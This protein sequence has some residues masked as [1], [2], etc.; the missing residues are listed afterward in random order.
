MNQFFLFRV[1]AK[2]PSG[3]EEA[4]KIAIVGAGLA[5]VTL[6]IG[7]L[8]QTSIHPSSIHLYE[9]AE[10]FSEIGAGVASG[11]NAVRAL[12]LISPRIAEAYAKCVTHNRDHS[13]SST[14]LGLRWGMSSKNGLKKTEELIASLKYEPPAWAD[15][16]ELVPGKPILARSCVH[17][18]AFLEELVKFIP[19]GMCSFN[20]TLETISDELQSESVTLTF[21]DGTTAD[22]DIVIGCDGVKSRTR[23]VLFDAQ[24][25]APRFTGQYAYR[26]LVP[27]DRAVE[28]LG[29]T[30]AQNGHLYLGYG[31]YIV[32]YPVEHGKLMNLVAQ[33]SSSGAWPSDKPWIA[34]VTR[35]EMLQDFKGWSDKLL[36]LLGRVERPEQWAL[37]EIAELPKFWKGR[38]CLMGDAAHSTT[39]HLGAGSG[40][41]FEDAYVLSNL[42]GMYFERAT[43]GR[44]VGLES[45]FAA[46]ELARKERSQN[47]VRLSRD[48]GILMQLKADVGDDEK[49]IGPISQGRYEWI[50]QHDLEGSLAK[51]I[52]TLEVQL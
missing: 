5:G 28:A 12:R 36:A 19:D 25:A 40:M 7:L 18:A 32:T 6:A 11:P 44:P 13:L 27:M 29:A 30:L 10:Q 2:M 23:N 48:Q 45:T 43:K 21:A 52:K 20:K 31:S 17:R 34:P 1:P 15:G 22:A 46:F 50:W 4:P 24:T 33:K 35:E 47:L 3:V 37:F 8:N 14:W 49:S 9:A 51:A 41:A 39:P 16:E 42:L 26:L 38:V